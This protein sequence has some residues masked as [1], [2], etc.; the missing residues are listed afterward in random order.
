MNI[1]GISR[2]EELAAPY[3]ALWE[4]N[5]PLEEIAAFCRKQIV[6]AQI[7]PRGESDLCRIL[8]ASPWGDM[9]LQ[10]SFLLALSEDDDE[11]LS[12]I[13]RYMTSKYEYLGVLQY[14]QRILSMKNGL[15]DKIRAFF[16]HHM[17]HAHWR[18]S[19][20]P[21][22]DMCNIMFCDNDDNRRAISRYKKT[23]YMQIPAGVFF[24]D[25]PIT[26]IP[27][28]IEHAFK[29]YSVSL[30]EM[31]MTLSGKKLSKGMLRTILQMGAAGILCHLLK[32]RLRELSSIL[33]PRDL[34][35]CICSSA[36]MCWALDMRSGG[37]AQSH[38]VV[39]TL[40][41]LIPGICRNTIDPL[42]NTP[43]WYC[44]YKK[45]PELLVRTL[46]KY[47]CDPDKRN[48]LNLSYRICQEAKALYDLSRKLSK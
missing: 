1:D 29:R 9:V 20:L 40:E 48:Y 44:Q 46:L 39:D 25:G 14:T 19:S 17:R 11:L 16:W 43:L 31:E 23:G 7:D 47:G 27:A 24:L 15:S 35:F 36:P 5:A 28:K 45:S 2:I 38:M 3:N 26:T 30:F 22:P 32:N 37:T 8:Q 21:R 41:E 10:P 4:R 13:G 6:K 34:L 12:H 42:G 33:S 18:Y